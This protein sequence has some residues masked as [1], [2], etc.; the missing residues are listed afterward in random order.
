MNDTHEI[1]PG[2][3]AP[4]QGPL[5][6]LWRQRRIRAL[7][8]VALAVCAGAAVWAQQSTPPFCYQTTTP[9]CR[10]TLEQAEQ[11]MRAAPGNASIAS[12]LEQA[13]TEVFPATGNAD[14]MFRVK[15][16]PASVVH[17]P[18]FVEEQSSGGI[19]SSMHGCTP[20]N[21]PNLPTAC[22]DEQQLLNNVVQELRDARPDCS[23]SNPTLVADRVPPYATI[24]GRN[25]VFGGATYGVIDYGSKKFNVT[26]TCN[27]TLSPFVIQIF[28]RETFS[29]APGFRRMSDNIGNDGFGDLTVPVLCEYT[30]PARKIT[31]PIQQCASCAASEYPVHP[32][33]GE[34]VRTEPD[35][36][37]AGRTFTRYYRSLRQFRNNPGF[38]VGWTHTFSDR[39]AGSNGTAPAAV[40]DETGSYEG[41]ESIGANRFRGVNSADTVLEYVATGAVRW[42]LRLPEGE[43]REFDANKRLT[44]IRTP[45]DPR[46]DVTLAYVDGLLRTATDGQGRVLRFEYNGA[47]LLTRI[48]LPDGNAFAYGYDADRNLTTV[49]DGYGRMRRYHYAEAGLIGDASQRNHLTGITAETGRRFADVRYDARGRVIESRALGTPHHV[50]TVRYD[51]DTRATV[52][53]AGGEERV[54]TI[55][56]GLYRRIVG[57]ATVGETT[58]D[59]QTFD[60]QGRLQR[61]TDRRGVNTDYEYHA[62]GAYRSATVEAVG[63]PEQRREEIDRDPATNLLT[64]LRLRDAA[65]TLQAQTRWTYNARGQVLTETD[66]DPGTGATRTTTTAYCEAADV[67]AGTCSLVGL[68]KSVDGP[69]TDVVDTTR[70]GYRM[71]DAPGCAVGPSACTYRKGDLWKTT[72]ARGQIVEALA[73]DGAGRIVSVRDVAGVVTDVEYDPRGWLLATKVRGTDNASEHDDRIA[74]IEYTAD[75]LVRRVIR[76]DGVF[77]V[78][79]Y[80]DAQRL[81]SIADRDGNTIS[82]TLDGAGHAIRDDTRD[83]GGALL[84]T[85]AR[86]FD[87]LGRLRAVTDADNRSTTFDYDAEGALTKAADPLSRETRAEY[88]PLGRLTRSLRNATATASADDRAETLHRYDALDRITRITDPK[89]LHTEYSYNGFG[90][91]IEQR[92]PDTGVTT[93]THD[94]AGNTTGEVDANGRSTQYLY[95]ALDRLRAVDYAAAVPDETFG[96]D[97]A[98]GDC[99]PGEQYTAGRLA[100]TADAEGST[101]YCYNRFGDVVRKVQRTGDQTFTLRWVYQADGRLQKVVYPDLTEVDY[102][103]DAQGRIREI[104]VND[105]DARQV[106]LTGATYRPFG[107]VSGWTYGN[108]LALRRSFDANGLPV[109]V[110]DGPANGNSIGIALGYRFDA[111]GNLDRLRSGR[112]ND[113]AAMAQTY[114]Y[115]GLDRLTEVRDAQA[116][117]LERYAYDRTGNRLSAS[118][119]V[120]TG[121]GGGPGD[122]GTPTYTFQTTPYTYAANSHRL[123]AVGSEPREY[124]AA[125][126][127]TQLGDPNAPGGPRRQFAYNDGNRMSAVS[128]LS[129][130]LATYGYNA[131]GERVRK[132]VNGANAYAVYDNDG[133]WLGDFNANGQPQRMAIWLDDLPVGVIVGS[134]AQRR[135]YYLEADAL[136]TPRAVID[137]QRNVAVWR[138][139]ALGEAFGRDGIEGD[140]DGDGQVFTL[141]MRFP[142][143]RYDAETGFHYN[144]F[145]D[146]DPTT[147]R[148]VESD[149]IGLDGGMSTYGYAGGS[150][151]MYDDPDGLVAGKVA[152][153]ITTR[154]ILP[155]LGINLAA[156]ASARWAMKKAMWA[157]QRQAFRAAR[158]AKLTARQSPVCST[159]TSGGRKYWIKAK[160]F[161]GN[162]VYQRDDLINPR[163][164]DSRGRSNL[165]RMQKGLSPIGSDGK[166][167]NLHHML[168]SHNGPI[169]EM[170]ANFHKGYHSIIHINPSSI[171]SGINRLAFDRWRASYWINRSRDFL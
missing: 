59:T 42:R 112:A 46:Q 103:Y 21:D 140:P 164:L 23:H 88:D 75:G 133:R 99:M 25:N 48:V 97:G 9:I 33:T 69:R 52:F 66:I 160:E 120:A 47:K 151:L 118:E 111:A 126:N 70:F 161:R 117:L 114:A 16:Q 41:F 136:G 12:L 64:E 141:D 89:G 80:D 128:N 51:S 77:V 153:S 152:L 56:P 150:P 165:E 102:L 163:L 108:G 8:A 113:P 145:R 4:V 147:G 39:V 98:W 85:V 63:T 154:H 105:N 22:L 62:S 45:D 10:D 71:S 125:G 65:G 90:D 74:R 43:L 131:L 166:S 72:N 159:V 146:Y 57:V 149:P 110:E 162:K 44:A 55:Q 53:S 26:R 1:E 119:W 17:G 20:G 11:A 116:L 156:R 142:G 73:Y 19:V 84:Q 14:Y 67:T 61:S 104:G 130:T 82:Y 167:L 3:T 6:R 30:G 31:G 40:I 87:T 137:P 139:D 122:G 54:Y 24:D 171:P 158:A 68:V 127:L 106:L 155:R 37:F 28:R 83:A 169:A 50:T 60:A 76:P 143:Q 124:D 58:Q 144:Y 93:W 148:Y 95:D 86:T 2:A 49:D 5:R 35:F 123:L 78:F 36:A 135:V 157:A 96:Y 34:K 109:A 170:T 18:S 168:Q 92:S 121:S 7:A 29:C 107:P 81:T 38:A 134:G 27:G 129:G 13:E 132:T 32:A 101:T 15:P 115:D 138:W 91:R 94:A 100:R 79:G